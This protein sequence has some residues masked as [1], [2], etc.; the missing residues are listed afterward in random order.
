MSGFCSLCPSQTGSFLL[1]NSMQVSPRAHGIGKSMSLLAASRDY[2]GL[3][4]GQKTSLDF[5][6]EYKD[7]T[8]QD[9]EELK[10]MLEQQ[11]GYT[12]VAHSPTAQ[13]A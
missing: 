4:E 5:A 6:K 3:K 8:A 2:F 11:Q 9:K 12:I 10:V 13:A 7:L 1:E